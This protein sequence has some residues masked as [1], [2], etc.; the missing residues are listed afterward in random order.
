MKGKEKLSHLLGTG[1]AKGDP[2]FHIW[3][4][5]DSMIMSWLWNSMLHEISITSMF[6]STKDMNCSVIFFPSHCVFQDQGSG[7]D[8]TC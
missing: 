7:K 3:D 1:P 2:E 6:L 5:E 8:W 4:E